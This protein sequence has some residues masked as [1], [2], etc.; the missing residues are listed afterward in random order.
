MTTVLKTFLV[1][2]AILALAIPAATQQAP[3]KQAQA[4]NKE[5]VPAYNIKEE[6][7]LLGTVESIKEYECPISGT[8]GT[9]LVF[10][11]DG[12]KYEVHVAPLKWLEEYGIQLKQGDN[13][14]LIGVKTTYRD[15]PAVLARGIERE[16]DVFYFRDKKGRPLW[17]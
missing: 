6:V 16:N 10:N 8:M 1:G 7:R 2:I 4:G 13:I 9:H 14:T 17:R 11:V 15:L 12:K 5:P 3:V